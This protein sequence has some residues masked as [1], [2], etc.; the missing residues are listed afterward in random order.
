M[1]PIGGSI[2]LM[3]TNTNK[4]KPKHIVLVCRK[5]PYGNSISREALDIALAASVYEQNLSIIFSGDGVWQL[6]NQ[7]DSQDILAKNHQKLLSVFALYDL[8]DIYVEKKALQQR[9]ISTKNLSVTAKIIDAQ[10]MFKL[11]QTADIILNF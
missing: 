3:T 11:M 5:P 6:L 7:Q 2:N 8:N 4:E 10:N 1:N 9:H